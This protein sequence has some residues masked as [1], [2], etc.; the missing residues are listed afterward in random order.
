MA[1]ET[2]GRAGETNSRAG[3]TDGRAGEAAVGGAGGVAGGSGNRAAA[4]AV[5]GADAGAG[6]GF[7]GFTLSSDTWA[8]AHPRMVEAIARANEG[9]AEPYGHD[10]C[11][12]EA[13]AAFRRLFGRDDLSVFFAMNGTG[14]NVAALAAC[15]G[16]GT[17]VV[18]AETAHINVHETGAPERLAGV[19]LLASPAEHGKLLPSSIRE[20][21]AQRGDPHC[22]LP[23]A[24]SISQ[25][26]ELGCA[27]TARELREIADAAHGCGMAL[28]MD[29]ARFANAVAAAGCEPAALSCGAGVDV[30]CFGGTKNGFVFGEAIV[31]FNQALAE[32]FAWLHK[33]Y[34]QLPSKARYVAAQF[35]AALEGGLWLELAGSANRAA[36]RLAG[37]LASILRAEVSHPVDSNMVFVR[38]PPAALAAAA[39]L[40]MA[41][42]GPGGELRLVTSYL[43]ADAQIDGFVAALRREIAAAT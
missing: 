28:H 16:H 6:C 33:Q 24:V 13:E 9:Y 30:M 2:D 32:R 36:A 10:A 34:L 22:A 35:L 17:G 39:R 25:T 8:P 19:K 38:L 40:S 43:A 41:D 26:T 42:A 37:G 4:G 29:G 11:C 3:G 18:C 12:R 20:W 21:A 15:A 5:D 31:F 27:Y 14:A 1:N 23:T 7:H